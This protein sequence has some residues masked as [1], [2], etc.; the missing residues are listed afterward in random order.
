MF[1]GNERDQVALLTGPGVNSIL[2]A[3]LA[4]LGLELVTSRVHSVHH[5][6]GAGVTV[7]YTAVVRGLAGIR[8]TEYL[9]ATTAHLK[10]PDAPGLVRVDTGVTPVY[11]WRHPGDPELPALA[12]AC[13][14]SLLSARLG[15][16]VSTRM[17]AYR[18][19]RR[20]V[21]K[22]SYADGSGAFAK[23]LRPGHS[24]SLAER[25]RMLTAAGVP[26]PR[27]LRDDPD[28][29]VLLTVGP[30]RPLSNLLAGGMSSNDA[31]DMFMRIT[32]LLDALPS[33]ALTLP[34][35]P[36]WSERVHHYAHA[37]S[38]VLPAYAGRINAIADGVAALMA[39]SD[40]GPVVP[41]HG[42]FYEANVFTEGTEISSLLD[43][44]SLGPGHR[45]DDYACLLGHM[46]VL[47]HLAPGTYK[48]LRPILDEWTRQAGRQ[49]DPVS[50]WARAAGVVLSLVSGARREGNAPWRAD[51]EGRLAAAE[52]WLAG[53]RQ[54]YARRGTHINL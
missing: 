14:P 10:R 21:V 12:V 36:A 42:D 51:A 16:Q 19:T 15:E 1:G 34:T 22:V 11:V 44:D 2:G 8:G 47:D 45:V 24:H 13:T 40:P 20:A 37:A 29:L 41:V 30:G 7:G 26:S 18:P 27:V 4:P 52:S 28:G 43:V 54:M 31:S 39:D 17:V 3:A 9:C 46:S 48:R 25:H 32:E 38:T 6:P 50:L 49:V 23:V 53:A 5:R 35:H 33:E